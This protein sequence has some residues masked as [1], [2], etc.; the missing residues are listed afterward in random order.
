MTNDLTTTSILALF[1]TNKEERQSFALSLVS[2]I[3]NGN[4]DPLNVHLQVKCMES[5]IKLL[6]ENTIYKKSV[7]EA[8][9]KQNQK[10]FTLNGHKIEIKETGVKYNFDNCGD[11]EWE[12]QDSQVKAHEHHRSEREKFLKTIPAKGLEI[13]DTISGEMTT[14]YPPSKSSTTSIAVTLK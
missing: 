7:L 1:E 13:V 10:S 2:E 5:I 14:I 4:I 8:A 3:E 9:E 12:L 11:T 6:N